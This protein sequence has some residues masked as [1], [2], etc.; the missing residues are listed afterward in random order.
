MEISKPELFIFFFFFFIM[1]CWR[2][3]VRSVELHHSVRRHQSPLF[4][5]V[6]G[7]VGHSPGI[8]SLQRGQP[9]QPSQSCPR[10]TQ[11]CN[12]LGSSW[13]SKY[14]RAANS[15]TNALCTLVYFMVFDIK[16]SRQT[17]IKRIISDSI[18]S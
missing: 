18:R 15:F 10:A 14:S 17:S 7:V 2:W 3:E 5:L 8:P 9:E 6:A 4:S 11:L 12:T 1:C 13:N 16:C